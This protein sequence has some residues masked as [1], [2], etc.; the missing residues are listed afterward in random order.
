MSWLDYYELLK[1]AYI[2]DQDVPIRDL[3]RA[4]VRKAR[5]GA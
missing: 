2:T 5:G 3:V 1:S 4:A